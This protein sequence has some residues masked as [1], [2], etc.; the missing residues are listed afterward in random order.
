MAIIMCLVMMLGI[1]P[2]TG[3][4][5]NAKMVPYSKVMQEMDKL[6]KKN[7]TTVVKLQ[8]Q[9][10]GKIYV[11]KAWIGE[12]NPDT[13]LVDAVLTD[14]CV[15]VG[16]KRYYFDSY[17][18]I[19]L[20]AKQ[21]VIDSGKK[22]QV[23]AKIKASGFKNPMSILEAISSGTLVYKPARE[24]LVVPESKKY[25]GV[26]ESTRVTTTKRKF[27]YQWYYKTP[28][29]SWKKLPSGKKAIVDIKYK[30]AYKDMSVYCTVK[31]NYG[32]S[33]TTEIMKINWK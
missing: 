3:L 27:T 9:K 22:V 10:T 28:T 30:K 2:A 19:T 11:D 1:I 15:V 7:K 6:A 5:A 8:N 20:K 25:Y 12:L 24:T 29:T 16:S 23:S 17:N 26:S 4:A 33:A 13:G 21:K 32:H 18:T 14:Y 31:D